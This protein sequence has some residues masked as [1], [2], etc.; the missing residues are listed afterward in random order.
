MRIPREK[1]RC[2]ELVPGSQ[3]RRKWHS[4]L[5]HPVRDEG[6]PPYIN[7]CITTSMGRTTQRIF[8]VCTIRH[9]C[10]ASL[11]KWS[12]MEGSFRSVRTTK[13]MNCNEFVLVTYVFCILCVTKMTVVWLLIVSII[14]LIPTGEF[15]ICECASCGTS[16]QYCV[17]YQPCPFGV[18]LASHALVN[19]S[20][21]CWMQIDVTKHVFEWCSGR[22]WVIV[23]HA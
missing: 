13:W 5:S 17:Y 9:M 20:H 18:P 16:Q 6:C 8:P 23:F 21:L 2:A 7:R 19:L 1:F 12:H 14:I 15:S 10:S 3:T 22:V 11:K 4:T